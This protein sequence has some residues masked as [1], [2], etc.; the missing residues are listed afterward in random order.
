MKIPQARAVAQSAR[1]SFPFRIAAVATL[2]DLGGDE[3]TQ[4]YLQ[5]LTTGPEQRLRV[6]AASAL[7]RI[8][9]N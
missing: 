3:A 7:K 8:S 1:A 5:Q 9:I 4:A 6:P 2:G